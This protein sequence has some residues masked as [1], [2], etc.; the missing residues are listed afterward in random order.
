MSDKAMIT[1]LDFGR[2][3]PPEISVED[4]ATLYAQ[5][6]YDLI[7]ELPTGNEKAMDAHRTVMML[8]EYWTL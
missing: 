4:R 1:N 5:I 2:E 7:D 3:K 8:P 6:I